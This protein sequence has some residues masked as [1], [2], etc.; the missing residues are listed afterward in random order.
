MRPWVTF[1]FY[2]ATVYIEKI[3]IHSP[4]E[5]K[6]IMDLVS[7]VAAIQAAGLFNKPSKCDFFKTKVSWLGN[8]VLPK[9]T[10]SP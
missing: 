6:H 4:H 2:C 10:S 7:V 5:E 1:V 9:G 8:M 3:L